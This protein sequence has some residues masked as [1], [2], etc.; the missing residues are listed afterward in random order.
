MEWNDFGAIAGPVIGA[1]ALYLN[2]RTRRDLKAEK[3]PLVKVA[4]APSPLRLPEGW[5]MMRLTLRSRSNLGYR[6]EA[7]RLIRPWGAKIVSYSAAYSYEN[8]P[9]G[10]PRLEIPA[11]VTAKASTEL[12]VAPMGRTPTR[13]HHWINNGSGEQHHVDF[14]VSF[15]PSISSR[16]LRSLSNS[17]SVSSNSRRVRVM[18]RVIDE[19]EK[20]RLRIA[21]TTITIVPKAAATSATET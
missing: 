6:I 17:S 7:V 18:V 15:P 9:N 16:I 21:N 8:S 4:P 20:A 3:T 1:L 12:A 13:T 2:W 5:A 14:L 19:H 11:I 10:N